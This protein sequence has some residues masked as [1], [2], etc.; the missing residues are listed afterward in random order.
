MSFGKEM[1]QWWLFTTIGT[2]ESTAVDIHLVGA[3][4]HWASGIRAQGSRLN[5]KI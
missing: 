3:I 1:N 5:Q 2:A 4:D